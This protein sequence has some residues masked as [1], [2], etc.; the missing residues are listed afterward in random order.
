[1]Y[2]LKSIFHNCTVLLFLESV[3]FFVIAT[4]LYNIIMLH[5]F[6]KPVLLLCFT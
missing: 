5:V 1:M 3:L 6:W 2:I 4:Y